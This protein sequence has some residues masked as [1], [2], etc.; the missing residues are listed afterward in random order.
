MDLEAL[1]RNWEEFGRTDPL[2]SILTDPSKKNNRWDE[3]EFFATGEAE[4]EV[5]MDYV[6]TLPRRPR[7][8]RALDFGCGV[9]R[10]TQALCR[11]F[12]TVDGVDI[13]ASMI[14]R[15][16][17]HNR[18]GPRC[19]YHVNVSP[20][21]RLVPDG[22][23]D[24]VYSNIVLQHMAPAYA[25]GYIREFVRVLAPDGLAVF[26]V[27]AGPRLTVSPSDPGGPFRASIRPAVDS[28]VATPGARLELRAEVT[29]ASP[30]PWPAA[31]DGVMKYC[32]RLG[33]H[34]RDAAGRLL[35]RDD[36][37]ADLPHDVPPGGRVVLMLVAA[38]PR[39]PGKYVL[40][41]DMVQE[42]VAWFE[43]RGSAVARLP[44]RVQGPAAG[45]APAVGGPPELASDAV[46]EMHCIA[47]EVVRAA[48]AR[49]G[50]RLEDAREYSASGPDFIGY[51]YAVTR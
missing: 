18:F 41:L 4:I 9:G 31:R 12:E 38:A 14:E 43:D 51:R 10:L 17:R 7:R 2:W 32:V 39:A 16:R 37:R 28:L 40:E 30:G 24:L 48:V 22:T 26:Q 8:R 3:R 27:P 13:A 11:H 33:N 36:G 25:L 35:Q 46:M 6:A 29:N 49:A 21:L 45:R 19:T 15:A 20:D 5:L 47:P 23:F 42:H 34:W 44:V 50:G 1:R